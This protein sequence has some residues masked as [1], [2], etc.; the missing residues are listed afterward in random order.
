M[1]K[2]RCKRCQKTFVAEKAEPFVTCSRC[3]KSIP[4]GL[5]ACTHW[6]G[7]DENGLASESYK[8]QAMRDR[9]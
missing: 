6:Q 4:P 5:G 8:G 3:R 1:V 7:V 2:K 9:Q